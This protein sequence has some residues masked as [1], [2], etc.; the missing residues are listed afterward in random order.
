M[1]EVPS[2]DG[3]PSRWLSEGF[4]NYFM[5]LVLREMHG[6]EK[7]TLNLE[8]FRNQFR[9]QCISDPQLSTTPIIRV[10]Q[11][12]KITGLLQQGGTGPSCPA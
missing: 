12:R 11:H 1:W 10:W 3:Q 8:G 2:L 7:F 6:R 9:S 4:A 5:A